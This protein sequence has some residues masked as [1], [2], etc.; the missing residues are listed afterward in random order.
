VPPAQGD[1]R[2]IHRSVAFGVDRRLLTR[3]RV[4][5]W[6]QDLLDSGTAMFAGIPGG[7]AVRKLPRVDSRKFQAR[8]QVRTKAPA[9][10][11]SIRAGIVQPGRGR[12]RN[13]N[14]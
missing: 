10:H 4:R 12:F 14:L 9:V 5:T 2:V 7:R 8:R 3:P 13:R 6:R 1:R 11:E